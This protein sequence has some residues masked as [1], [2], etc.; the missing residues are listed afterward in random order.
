MGI[1][2]VRFR[3]TGKEPPPS[4]SALTVAEELGWS[5]SRLLG[6]IA[7]GQLPPPAVVGGVYRFPLHYALAVK[8]DGLCLPGTHSGLPPGRVEAMS[9]A[10]AKPK[11]TSDRRKAIS[12]AVKTAQKRGAVKGG[13]K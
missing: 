12:K 7:T 8:C 6:L 9:R 13:G 5:V 4:L 1:E 2:D 3:P 10:R 11:T